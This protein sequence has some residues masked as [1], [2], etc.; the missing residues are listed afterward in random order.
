MTARPLTRQKSAWAEVET[1]AARTTERHF[2]RN[3]SDGRLFAI[4][5]IEPMVGWHLSVSF[6]DHRGTHR[7]YPTWDEILHARDQL[8]PA[9][10]DFVMHLPAS[11]ADYIAVHPTTFHLYQHPAPEGAR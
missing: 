9:E 2:A 4:V 1:P 5:A 11:D 7:R 3:T 6:R 10:I 8:L